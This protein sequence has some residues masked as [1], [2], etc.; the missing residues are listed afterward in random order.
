D[1]P[2]I[3]KAGRILRKYRLD[4]LP[5]FW[6]VIR[7][8][9]SLVGP[10]PERAYFIEKIVKKAPHYTLVHQVKP[11]ITSWG[12]VKFGYAREVDEM[13]ERSNYD[14]IYLANMSVAVDFKIL[15]H[16]ISTVVLGK[17]V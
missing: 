3:T 5:Q 11:G 1:D 6:N 12:M 2:R 13:V 14:L 4:E 17:G 9:M 16:T 15:L 7:G 10:R 8:E